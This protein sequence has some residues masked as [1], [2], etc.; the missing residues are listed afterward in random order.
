MEDKRTEVR[1]AAAREE[2]RRLQERA[3]SRGEGECY[4][5][6]RVL[7]RRARSLVLAVRRGSSRPLLLRA[8][9]SC[10]LG[11]RHFP[12]RLARPRLRVVPHRSS[13]RST[14][15]SNFVPQHFVTY[16]VPGRVGRIVVVPVVY[17]KAAHCDRC[18]SPPP[19]HSTCSL[20]SDVAVVVVFV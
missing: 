1:G 15:S 8:A 10:L 3:D 2:E 20:A 18:C 19:P 16:N 7:A 6:C 11:R 5:R 14:R 4:Y 12:K 17:R 13:Q 9:G